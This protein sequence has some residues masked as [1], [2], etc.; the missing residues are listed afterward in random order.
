MKKYNNSPIKKLIDL[1]SA[2]TRM[3]SNTRE[4]TGWF[5]ALT[6]IGLRS[7]DKR[8]GANV[9]W[10]PMVEREAEDLYSSDDIAAKMVDLIPD[11][12][13]REWVEI[14]STEEAEEE[15]ANL[16]KESERLQ[17]QKKYNKA[18]K[19]ARNYG[20]AGVFLAVD[21]AQ[22]D[23]REPLN[24]DSLREIKTLT[25]MSRWELQP[26]EINRDI[27]SENFGFPETYLLTPRTA[28]SDSPIIHHSRIIRFDGV[29][30]PRMVREQNDFWGDS[31]LN[32]FYNPLRNFN[33]A[34]DS[35]ASMMQDYKLTILK[36]KNLADI[37]GSG[38]KDKLKDRIQMM[39]LTKSVL[40]SIVID[41]E[42]ED[43]MNLT[44]SISGISDIIQEIDARLVAATGMPHTIILGEGAAGQFNNSGQSEETNFK[45][46]VA[47]QQE[48]I[49]TKPIDRIFEL[50]QLQKR[51]PFGGKV[52]QDI[53][54][55]FKPLWQL[56]DK[57]VAEVRKIIAETDK[58]YLET[59]VLDTEE[60]ANSRFG[61]DE[62]SLETTLDKEAREE[63]ESTREIGSE[64][65][66]A[67][68][69][70]EEEEEVT[71]VKIKRTK[72]RQDVI[73]KKGNK[74]LVLNESRTKTL[75]VHES[76]EEAKKQLQAIESN[77]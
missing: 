8:T 2:A 37:I 77:K 39:D 30:L 1:S 28:R 41:A 71:D 75:G 20:G 42:D 43:F 57:E 32:R 7:K 21:D 15:I 46:M 65:T 16:K 60:V 63:Q 26:H 34:H 17:I 51:G 4:S 73:E 40:G 36:I 69:Q 49:L 62:Y 35:L 61:G 58:I 53:S 22:E 6:G 56:D 48:V 14:K 70:P 13:T 27:T 59:G 52:N 47:A 5:N 11:E 74:W 3:D 31:V 9:K 38:D 45:D 50:I 76:L 10:V 33:L 19:W 67:M 12:G 29:D 54:W 24:I 72:P 66:Q 25:V 18:W 23:L 55:N 64:E 68:F 44:T